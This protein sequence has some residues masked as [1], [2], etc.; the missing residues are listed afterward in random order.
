MAAL[1]G[2]VWEKPMGQIT[3][4]LIDYGKDLGLIL[5]VMRKY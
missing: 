4:V 1:G 5:I 3:Q 2:V